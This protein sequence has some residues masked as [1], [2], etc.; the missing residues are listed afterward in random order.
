MTDILALRLVELV[1]EFVD[2]FAECA[3]HG[4]PELDGGGGPGRLG[5]QQGETCEKADLTRFSI[6][7][8]SCVLA[9]F[10]GR[11]SVS[12]GAASRPSKSTT[13]YSAVLADR[14]PPLHL[15]R[16][17]IIC[18]I[19]AEIA[20]HANASCSHNSA[21]REIG[22]WFVCSRSRTPISARAS[23]TFEPN[24]A[25]LRAWIS[26]QRPHLVIH[27]GDVTVDGADDEDDFRYCAES[28]SRPSRRRCLPCRA[29]TTS[30]SPA[31]ASTGECRS[32]RPLAPPS[33]PRL[34]VARL[35]RLA[36]DRAQLAAPRQRRG[37][38]EA[39]VRLA[40]ARRWRKPDG[41]RIAWFLH[42]PLVHR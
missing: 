19:R 39:P 18:I 14:F 6:G 3:A 23:V 40:G 35:R 16:A 10:S 12:I 5:Q 7:V 15:C 11:F 34:L 20:R 30:A 37:G 31:S 42:M 33:R 21:G 32:A 28:C 17:L 38:G 36:A 1:G 27:G 41:R 4:V 22:R 26:A 8:S 2:A 29:T 24:W 9:A 25:P 13:P